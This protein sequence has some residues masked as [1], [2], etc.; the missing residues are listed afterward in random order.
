MRTLRG[1]TLLVAVIATAAMSPIAPAAVAG[2]VPAPPSS[3]AGISEY[4]ELGS[5][6]GKPAAIRLRPRAE[7]GNELSR[8]SAIFEIRQDAT[9]NGRTDQSTGLPGSY[10]DQHSLL[11]LIGHDVLSW[12]SIVLSLLVS[13]AVL[14]QRSRRCVTRQER[15]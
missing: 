3:A 12:V 1:R 2:A 4:R 14:V 5:A 10:Y 8:A 15:N 6:I 7:T 9:K 13:A 11:G